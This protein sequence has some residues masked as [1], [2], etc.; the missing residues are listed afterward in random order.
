MKKFKGN[1]LLAMSLVAFIALAAC[2][3]QNEESQNLV[4]Q[5]SNSIIATV[6]GEEIYEE[7]LMQLMQFQFSMFGIDV[8]AEEN[9]ELLE[10]FKP[11]LLD[12]LI[13][14][15]ILIQE[16]SGKVTVS[17]EEIDIY[18][19]QVV[20]QLPEDLTFEEA[21]EIQGYTEEELRNEIKEMLMIEEL[22]TLN[23]LSENEFTVTEDEL[24]EQYEKLVTEY[25]ENVEEFEAVQDE[26]RKSIIQSKY[27]EELREQA[28]IETFI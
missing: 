10:S 28:T 14:E 25:G 11:Q 1:L 19:E 3:N 4:D 22:L 20:S 7:D 2:G 21:L 6:N 18:M 15:K 27:I 12:T 5:D 16:A 8:R 9:Q 26:L 17:E 23:H 24:L 13:L